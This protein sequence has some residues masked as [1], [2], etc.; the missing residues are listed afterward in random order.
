MK[1]GQTTF[2]APRAVSGPSRLTAKAL[3]QMQLA[4]AAVIVKA[5]SNIGMLLD[6]AD[7][8]PGADRVHRP[9]GNEKSVAGPGFEPLEQAHDGAIECGGADLLARHWFAESGGDLRAVLAPLSTCHISVLP[10]EL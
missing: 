4:P 7:R 8:Q 2:A 3:I 9:G 1:W 5:I 6:F 10:G